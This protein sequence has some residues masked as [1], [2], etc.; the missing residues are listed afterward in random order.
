MHMV[1]FDIQTAFLYGLIDAII[2]M[3]QPPGFEISGSNGEPLVCLV[4]KSL[5]GLKQ[6]GRIWNK[7][8]SNFLIAF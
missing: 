7:M 8:F 6:S 5:Y 1:Q 2:Y 4:L 3:L